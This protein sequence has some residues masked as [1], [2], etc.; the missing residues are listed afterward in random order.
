[1]T[2]VV[3][4]SIT[5]AWLFE[6]ERSDAVDAVMRKASSDGA[7]VP[8]LWRLEVANALQSAV[9]H[10]RIDAAFRDASLDDLSALPISV[11][12]E[13]EQHAWA[14]TLTLADRRRITVYDA[15]YLELAVRLRLPLATL[16]Q[17]LRAAC[18]TLRVAVRPS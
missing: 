7:V 17:E 4:A 10:K 15:A 6:D 5:I 16:A 2:L 12:P 8:S 9:R 11:D 14:T 13:T 1:M 18:R 3:D